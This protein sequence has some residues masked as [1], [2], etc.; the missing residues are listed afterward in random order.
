MFDDDAR[1]G[2]DPRQQDHETRDRDQ[3]SLTSLAG[4]TERRI[5]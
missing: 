5:C 3:T 4:L 1:W 2:A